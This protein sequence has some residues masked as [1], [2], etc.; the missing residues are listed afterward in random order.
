M[1][2]EPIITTEVLL[3]LHVPPGGVLFR[4]LLEPTQSPVTPVMPLGI[5]LTVTVMVAAHEVEAQV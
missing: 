1:P 5:G 3:L 4:V 2:D